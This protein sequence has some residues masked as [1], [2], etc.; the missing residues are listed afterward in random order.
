MLNFLIDNIF[1][2]FDGTVFQETIENPMGANCAP[3]LADL[4]VA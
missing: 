2:V 3:L 1:L 4:V